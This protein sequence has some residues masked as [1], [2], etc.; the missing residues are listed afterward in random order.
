MPFLPCR[1][2][3]TKSCLPACMLAVLHASKPV[4][5]HAWRPQVYLPSSQSG[6][7]ASV[8]AVLP[9]S[10]RAGSRKKQA[11]LPARSACLHAALPASLAKARP[12]ASILVAGLQTASRQTAGWQA[13]RQAD[14][15]DCPQAGRHVRTHINEGRQACQQLRV[16]M[17]DFLPILLASKTL[18]ACLLAIPACLHI[19]LPAG[20][21]LRLLATPACLLFKFFACLPRKLPACL[22]A[23]KPILPACLCLLSAGSRLIL[24]A[25]LACLP[26]F[27]FL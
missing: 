17:Q 13:G 20:N 4:E 25:C 22:P 16:D 18:L 6:L 26:V 5:T 7:G 9:S 3:P 8:Q 2:L 1:E 14:R 21:L 10:S 23:F 11:R 19:C 15:Q 27:L 12:L 24:P